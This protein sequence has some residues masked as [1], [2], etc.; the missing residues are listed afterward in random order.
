MEA[1]GF[2]LG[3]VLVAIVAWD[4]FQTVV[5]P[6]P[7]PGHIRVSRYVVR[8]SWALMK[9]LGR[10]SPATMRDNLYGLYGPGAAILLLA[11][12]L[13]LLILG[14]GLL[15]YALRDETSPVLPDI[16]SAIYLAASSVL[17]IGYG[18]FVPTG[19]ATRI[20]SVFAA[21][22]GLGA[23]ALVVTFLFSLYGS[24]QRRELA[25]VTLQA[26]AG[27]PPS[28]VA[29][30]ETY[31]SLEILDRLD[32]LFQEWEGWS[33]EV[34]DSHVA[35][36]ILGF[37]RSS[38]DNLSWIGALGTVLDAATL[39]VTTIDGLPQG[40]AELARRV[41]S[42]LAEDLS[43]LGF[44]EG[45]TAWLSRDDFE[46]ACDRLE[47]AG[48][49]L[50]DR[51]QAWGRFEAARLAYAPRLESMATYWAVAATSWLGVGEQ[52]RSAAHRQERR[53]EEEPIYL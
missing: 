14:F 34:L 44:A 21:V 24:Y 17:T 8:G 42:H 46:A 45:E 41:G 4:L 28:A 10:R 26:A 53:P 40:H 27:S 49:R 23:V 35:Y 1:L 25:I 48:F 9:R 29:L 13:G 20:F 52:V 12:W 7:T 51:G 50:V 3:L 19:P 11:V 5:V 6:R 16:W 38:H 33:A 18:D 37:F 30:L 36:P 32:S 2:A 22:G 47:R 31:A 15:L 43:N 39:V